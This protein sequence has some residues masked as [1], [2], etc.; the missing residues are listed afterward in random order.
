MQINAILCTPPADNRGDTSEMCQ[1]RA[2]SRIHWFIPLRK[3]TAFREQE[4][5]SRH[6]SGRDIQVAGGV[7]G[8]KPQRAWCCAGLGT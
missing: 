5:S 6:L 1:A 4:S 8:A 2:R 3:S 7:V